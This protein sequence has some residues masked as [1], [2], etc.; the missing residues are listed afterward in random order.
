MSATPD[1]FNDVYALSFK[2]FSPDEEITVFEIGFIPPDWALFKTDKE[3]IAI[4]R[5]INLTT[6]ND[7]SKT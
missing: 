7:K 6:G 5:N 1:F 2:V 3:S 4:I